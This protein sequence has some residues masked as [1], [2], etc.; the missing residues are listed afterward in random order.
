MTGGLGYTV[1]RV[2]ETPTF[3][4]GPPGVTTPDD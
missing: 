1:A 3:D 2:P 4:S